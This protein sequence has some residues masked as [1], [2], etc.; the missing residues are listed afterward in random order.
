LGTAINTARPDEIM[1]IL[2]EKLK[3]SLKKE[4]VTSNLNRFIEHIIL[5]LNCYGNLCDRKYPE[6]IKQKALECVN[7]YNKD[8]KKQKESAIKQSLNILQLSVTQ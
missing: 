1:V 3:D 4:S 2:M 7:Y 8:L 5:V 6:K